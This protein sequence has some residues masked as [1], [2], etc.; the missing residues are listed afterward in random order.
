MD[1]RITRHLDASPTAVYRA[2]LDGDAVQQWMVPDDM[3][4]EVHR[5][6]PHVGGSFR[7]TLT[8]RSAAGVGA[9]KSSARADTFHGR[10]VE[11]VPDTRV[12]Q[13]VE[14][15]TAD[16]DLQGEMRITY[17]LLAGNGGTDLTGTHQHLPP[18]LSPGDNE[19]GWTMSIDRLEALLVAEP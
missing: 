18:G 19:M 3:T 7:I 16:P 8:H 9:G 15:E 6:E 17:E 10:F 12:V 2:L 14:F 11:L 5:F 1:T 13:V 4:S